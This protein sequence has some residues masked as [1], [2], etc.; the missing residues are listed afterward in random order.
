MFN[1]TYNDLNGETISKDF[2]NLEEMARYMTVNM[3]GIPDTNVISANLGYY[4]EAI[5]LSGDVGYEEMAEKA[6]ELGQNADMLHNEEL[7]YDSEEDGD[8]MFPEYD[9]VDDEDEYYLGDGDLTIKDDYFR[10][11]DMLDDMDESFKK[12]Q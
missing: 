7:P 8:N 1:I 2:N 12:K 3:R 4:G 11:Y 10:D 5:G 9:I 6:I